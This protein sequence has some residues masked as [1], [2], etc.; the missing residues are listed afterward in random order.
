MCSPQTV[1]GA[2]RSVFGEVGKLFLLARF[3]IEHT[4][5]YPLVDVP[6]W[7]DGIC[8]PFVMKPAS[9]N[10]PRLKRPPIGNIWSLIEIG[11]NIATVEVVGIINF[12]PFAPLRWAQ[13]SFPC[14]PIFLQLFEIPLCFF[15]IRR[16]FCVIFEKRTLRPHK[17]MVLQ[18]GSQP[19]MKASE[20]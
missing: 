8:L 19:S 20:I 15:V 9:F 17:G 7:K 2:I 16:V 4:R 13:P 10:D 5:N 6:V 18:I 11:R 14:W 12:S 1:G 3:L